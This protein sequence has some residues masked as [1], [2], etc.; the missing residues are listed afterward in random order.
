[1]PAPMRRRSTFSFDIT[2][3]ITSQPPNNVAGFSLW[4]ETAAAN[5]GLFAITALPNHTGSLFDQ[6][7]GSSGDFPAA[8]TTTNSTCMP[9][10]L[11]FGRDRPGRLLWNK[12]SHSG[13]LFFLRPSPF[14][15]Q[16]R[17]RA[18]D[19]HAHEYD[20]LIVSTPWEEIFPGQR[21]FLRH[22]RHRSPLFTRS[23]LCR[24]PARWPFVSPAE[25][26]SWSPTSA[27]KRVANYNNGDS[28]WNAAH[29]TRV[30]CR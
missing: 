29:V 24:N 23:R 21:W 30:S 25:C 10:C 3:S 11:E 19:L 27:A 9:A 8:L 17:D 28:A 22:L 26:R 5:S 14:L 15:H 18:R 12:P 6:V 2:L 1:M 20:A 4:F 13:D 7:T 16:R